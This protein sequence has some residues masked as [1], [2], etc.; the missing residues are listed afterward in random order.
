MFCPNCGKEIKNNVNFCPSCGFAI[1][2]ED[3]ELNIGKQQSQNNIQKTEETNKD[4]K[5]GAGCLLVFCLFGLINAFFPDDTS[6]RLP[7]DLQCVSYKNLCIATTDV[8]FDYTSVQ[9]KDPRYFNSTWNNGW[10]AAQNACKAW[11]GRLPYIEEFPT[12]IEA[13]LAKKIKL[14]E[15][16]NYLTSNEINWFRVYTISGGLYGFSR[17]LSAYEGK[18]IYDYAL[19]IDK[20]ADWSITE[21]YYKS[22]TAYT[23]PARCV[24][25]IK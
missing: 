21:Q 8:K 15:H 25:P 22:G 6:P 10:A 3:K 5:M 11:G 1:K 7:K 16:A 19:A 2:Q 17:E 13:H 4:N 20:S 23:W 14:D 24:K 12:M 9:S 18:K